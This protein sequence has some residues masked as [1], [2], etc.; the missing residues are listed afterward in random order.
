M[1]APYPDANATLDCK[2][3]DL[4]NAGVQVTCAHVRRRFFGLTST[5]VPASLVT[6]SVNGG[7]ADVVTW[8][9]MRHPAATSFAAMEDVVTA[10]G[11]FDVVKQA[12]E[13]R[14]VHTLKAHRV[15]LDE[16]ELL[17]RVGFW[18]HG[19]STAGGMAKTISTPAPTPKA[20]LSL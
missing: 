10:T 9:L 15:R 18:N 14:D 7:E 16:R 19:D 2:V 8:M 6:V 5:R 4:P 3:E 20:R 11:T 1:A 12:L 17:R 13:Q